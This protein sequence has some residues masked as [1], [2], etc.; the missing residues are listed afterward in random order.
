MKKEMQNQMVQIQDESKIIT[1]INII[2]SRN[3]REEFLDDYYNCA[4]CG[5]EMTYTHVTHFGQQVV[6]EEAF[7]PSCNIRTKQESH[8]LQ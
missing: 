4:L 2:P 3:H 7:C 5:S 6:E 8:R 1:Q